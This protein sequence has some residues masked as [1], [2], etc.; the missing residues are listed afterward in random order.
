MLG[1]TKGQ[2]DEKNRY[3]TFLELFGFAIYLIICG[4]VCVCLQ[5]NTS[6]YRQKKIKAIKLGQSKLCRAQPRE[7]GAMNAQ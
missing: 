5:H 2:R 7:R 6:Y 3:A 4:C 1:K